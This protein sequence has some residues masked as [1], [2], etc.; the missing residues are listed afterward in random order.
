MSRVGVAV[1]AAALVGLAGC[2]NHAPPVLVGP[3]RYPA[4]LEPLVPADVPIAPALRERHET[5]WARLQTGDL[6]GASR[7]FSDVLK[8]APEFYPSVTGLGYVALAGRNY[9]QATREFSSALA[10]DAR[11]APALQGQMDASLGLGDDLG[12]L[13]A[14]EQLLAVDPS[15]SDLRSRLDVLQLRVAE[16]Q[17]Q[18]A[19][20]ERAAGRLDDARATLVRALAASPDNAIILRQL[21]DLELAQGSQDDAER[22]ARQAVQVD[23]GDPDGWATLGAVLEARGNLREAASAYGHAVSID[24]RPAWRDKRDSLVARADLEALPAEYRAIPSAPTVTRAQVAAMVDVNLAPL[25][26]SAPANA[27][28]VATDLRGNWAASWILP[29]VRAGILNVY[30]NHTFQPSAVV[31]RSDLALAMSRLL[32]LAAAERPGEAA[33]WR[34]AGRTF[35]DVPQS[36]QSYRAIAEVV[37]AGVMQCDALGRFWPNRPASGP[38]LAAAINAIR[39]VVER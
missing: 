33:K 25:V 11:Y 34:A 1:V 28:V 12:A 17:L 5:A 24:A 2:T 4:F 39:D 36:Y 31:R 37:G 18:V 38:E 13:T 20:R 7:E 23:A 19:A 27:V 14:L 35:P 8:A 9:R 29:V 32:E 10:V 21:A 16:A 15:R 30:A 6:R 3:P 22:H 26:A